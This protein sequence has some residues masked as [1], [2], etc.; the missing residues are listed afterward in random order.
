MHTTITY[1]KLKM[2][3]NEL[4]QQLLTLTDLSLDSKLLAEHI[5][6]FWRN[7]EDEKTIRSIATRIGILLE[8]STKLAYELFISRLLDYIELYPN[9][10]DI[11]STDE[12]IN[13]S[14]EDFYNFLV[15]YGKDINPLYIEDLYQDRLLVIGRMFYNN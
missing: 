10:K 15:S 13:M 4:E 8:A 2:V 14:R 9:H 7:I 12:I 6:A 11:I 1:I 3:D 5:T